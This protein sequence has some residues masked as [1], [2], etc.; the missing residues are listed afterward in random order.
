MVSPANQTQP[1][2]SGS[3]CLQSDREAHEILSTH[4]AIQLVQLSD[5]LQA[6]A[7]Q[8]ERAASNA[9]RIRNFKA[10]T[11]FVDRARRARRVKDDIHARLKRDIA[12]FKKFADQCRS[13]IQPPLPRRPANAL[14]IEV[15]AP[16]PRC[17]CKRSKHWGESATG[18]R[19]LA[20]G[21][22]ALVF[23][24]CSRNCPLL[25][26]NQEAKP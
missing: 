5:S 14:N 10:A 6:I 13:R 12:G 3:A 4:R 11:H 1:A 18:I 15:A 7:A 23:G 20:S 22:A 17:I 24:V 8:C 2:I 25:S 21:G 9:V 16:A 26:D 19:W